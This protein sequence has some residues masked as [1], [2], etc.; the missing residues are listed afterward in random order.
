MKSE[1]SIGSYLHEHRIKRGMSLK[2]V[3]DHLGIDI[4]LLSKIEQKI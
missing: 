2:I 4:S 3:A 1:K